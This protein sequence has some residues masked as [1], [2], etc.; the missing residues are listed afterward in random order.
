MH[1]LE[2]LENLI[3][4]VLLVDFFE[5]VCTDDR[6]QVS[7]HEIED[8]VNIPIVFR[9]NHILQP[10]DVLVADELLEEYDLTEGSLGVSCILEGVEVLFEGYDL[11]GAFIDGFPHNTV[12]SLPY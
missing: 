2:A 10:N 9:S 11:L 7:I 4:N 1:V 12:R 6:V 8:K 3:D 5:D